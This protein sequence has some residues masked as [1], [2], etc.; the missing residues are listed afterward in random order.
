MKTVNRTK[1]NFCRLFFPIFFLPLMLHAQIPPGGGGGTNS[2]SYTPLE[3]WYFEDTNTWQNAF[4]FNPVTFANL[5]SSPLGDG[6]AVVVDSSNQAFLQYNVYEADGT[7]NLA[8]DQGTVL[9]WY[10]PNWAGT[11]NDLD[12]L[13]GSGPGEWGRLLEVGAYTTNSDYG[14][15]S[16]YT[17]DVGA[18][19][20]FSS[21]TNDNSGNVYTISTPIE[22]ATNRW[23][24]IALTYS[25]TN[26]SLYLD[27]QLT[28]ND[29]AGL[30]IWPG[31]DV[32]SNGFYLGSNSN[33][34]LQAHGMFDDLRT[35]NVAMDS[36]T[37]NGHFNRE[38]GGYYMNPAN[39]GNSL[40]RSAASQISYEPFYN[41]FSGTGVVQWVSSSGSCI[42][43]TNVWL[44]NVVATAAGNGKM[45]ITFTVAGGLDNTPY[46]VL[47][48]SVLAP[49]K[50]TNQLAWAWEGQVF[51]CNTY[52]LPNLP[53]SIG[54]VV[55][56]TPTD[57][58]GDGLT[59][60]Y[61][62]YV[63]HTDANSYSSDGTGMSD[64][65]EIY[66]FGHTGIDPNADPDGDGLTNY[67]EYMGGTNPLVPDNY[68]I[69]LAEP[70][71]GLNL[72]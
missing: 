48:N 4:G 17:D 35:Y 58:D 31:T 52:T 15:W 2:P 51:H 44:T 63:S 49:P 54:F 18:N 40:I 70:K 21:Q 46:D 36:G 66:Y 14:W 27:G 24:F 61:E 57:T 29:P 20:Y 72:P 16:L 32:L 62:N 59:D 64:G 33:G 47:A 3:S 45:N 9:F 19:L 67:Q 71:F 25:S 41:Y 7:T 55:L 42:T 30:T 65:W 68:N 23:H 50:A 34:V 37:I 69:L 6:Q 8:V 13:I 43:S 12:Y 5:S 39:K 11:N 53:S 10:A 38:Q 22:W 1:Q 26:V 28:T 60:A 56:G